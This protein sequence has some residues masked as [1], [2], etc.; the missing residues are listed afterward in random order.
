VT[1]ELHVAPEVAALLGADGLARARAALAQPV[2][3]QACRQQVVGRVPLSVVVELLTSPAV[4]TARVA[5]AHA[6]CAPSRIVHGGNLLPRLEAVDRAGGTAAAF[7]LGVWGLFPHTVV[8][9]EPSAAQPPTRVNPEARAAEI[10][11]SVHTP[12]ARSAW[13]ACDGLPV[14]P[15]WR[16]HLQEPDFTIRSPEDAAELTG[17]LDAAPPGWLDIVRRERRCVAVT[18]VGLGLGRP[19]YQQRLEAAMRG[20]QVVA[21]VVVLAGPT[22]T[23]PA[24]GP[25][26]TPVTR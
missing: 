8:L 20:G 22:G 6:S 11:T 4:P 15:G 19:D 3:C 5:F 14:A 12:P 24:D 18:G 9:W 17:S 13:A 1:A 25:A 26:Q 2:R 10:R 23:G 7:T 21:G 16:L